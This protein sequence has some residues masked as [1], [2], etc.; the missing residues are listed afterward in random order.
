MTLSLTEQIETNEAQLK[1]LN[2]LSFMAAGISTITAFMF[3]VCFIATMYFTVTTCLTGVQ[4]K[5]LGLSLLATA[6]TFVISVIFGT[7]SDRMDRKANQI[8]SELYDLRLTQ[9]DLVKYETH[10]IYKDCTNCI[11]GQ[12]YCESVMSGFQN[13]GVNHC[14][15]VYCAHKAAK[16]LLEER[17]TLKE[18]ST[19]YIHVKERNEL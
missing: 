8:D 13:A 10:K 4:V 3:L 2:N 19:K 6:I 11:E 12:C 16:V 7:Y 15:Q 17:L 1:R 5:P 9:Q 14:S 18:L